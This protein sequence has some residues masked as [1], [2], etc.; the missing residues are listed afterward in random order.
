MVDVS[1][2]Y[3]LIYD[4]A[5]PNGPAFMSRTVTGI[6]LPAFLSNMFAKKFSETIRRRVNGVLGGLP[7]EN[8]K[9]LLRRDIRAIDDVLQDKKFLFGGKMTV[10][11]CAV[12]GQLAT[13][14]SLPYRQ[15]I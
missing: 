12:F 14:F 9:E 6:P 7:R 8:M 11:D 15:L 2:F 13:T 5:V 1:T 10:T 3:A 4:K